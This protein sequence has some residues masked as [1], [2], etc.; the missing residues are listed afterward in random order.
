MPGVDLSLTP[1]GGEAIRNALTR[2]VSRGDN[3]R[4]PLGE[5]GVTLVLSTR[6]RFHDEEDPDG[7][8]WVPLAQST[9]RRKV[10]KRRRRGPKHKLRV[11]RKLFKSIAHLATAEEVAVGTGDKRGP[12]HQLGGTPDMAPGP[13]A[14]PARAFLGISKEDEGDVAAILIRYLEAE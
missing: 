14:V 9:Q 13:A 8:D 10:N 2:L 6:Q 11:R 1:E 12:I 5:I 4:D 3:L 7:K